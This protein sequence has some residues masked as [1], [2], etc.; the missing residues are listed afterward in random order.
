MKKKAQ[1]QAAAEAK[2]TTF[3]TWLD[4]AGVGQV[5]IEVHQRDGVRVT[6]ERADGGFE[7]RSLGEEKTREF[8]RAFA[9]CVGSREK[10]RLKAEALAKLSPAERWALGLEKRR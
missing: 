6:V 9:A 7:S 2:P 5:C 3:E 1:E 4:F 8:Y 10:A